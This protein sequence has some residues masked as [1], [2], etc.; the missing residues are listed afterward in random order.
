[1]KIIEEVSLYLVLDAYIFH[2]VITYVRSMD[3]LKS[4]SY[5]CQLHGYI[6]L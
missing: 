5:C 4:I 2:L 6:D 1:M 3:T